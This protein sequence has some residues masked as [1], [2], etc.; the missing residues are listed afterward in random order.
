MSSLARIEDDLDKHLQKMD[1]I[2]TEYLR[3]NSPQEI[4]KKLK[5]P[6]RT[7]NI[8]LDE[9]RALASNNDSIKGRALTALRNADRHYDNL[10]K[11]AHL[12][13]DD[14]EKNGAIS[15]RLAA[16]KVIAELE[17]VRIELMH[18]AGALQDTEITKQII[19]TERKQRILMEIL[20]NT[21]GACPTC[22]PEVHRKLSEITNE[23]VTIPD[24][25]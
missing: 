2:V 7:V 3:G 18:K 21:V 9:W 1:S 11:S 5:V 23:V 15:N 4:S 14:A 22:R 16:I 17:K 20:R 25:V 8:F 19:E 24:D 12:A 13:L 10:I 6:I